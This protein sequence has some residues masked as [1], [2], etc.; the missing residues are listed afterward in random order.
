MEN[1]WEGDLVVF[2]W[3]VSLGVIGFFFFHFELN[4]SVFYNENVLLF[5]I[6]GGKK[7]KI[8]YF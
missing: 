2:L 3:A 5:S 8:N 1:N 4:F 6:I 7:T